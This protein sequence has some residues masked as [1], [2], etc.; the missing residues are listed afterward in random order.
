MSVE[1]KVSHP[2]KVPGKALIFSFQFYRHYE[3]VRVKCYKLRGGKYLQVCEE[4]FTFGYTITAEGGL[5]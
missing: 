2:C 1:N 5:Q 4:K 3:D